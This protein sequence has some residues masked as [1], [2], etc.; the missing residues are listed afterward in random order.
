MLLL[1]RKINEKIII[2]DNIIIT[3]KVIDKNKV[4]LGFEAPS[5]VTIDREE[6]HKQ[7]QNHDN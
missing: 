1:T 3:I 5:N 7:K 2:N 6:I 4:Q